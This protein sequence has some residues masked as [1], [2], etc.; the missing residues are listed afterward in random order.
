M[1]SLSLPPSLPRRK[2]SNAVL[3][4]L[5]RNNR[6]KFIIVDLNRETQRWILV[7]IRKIEN[8]SIEF[9]KVDSL[10]ADYNEALNIEFQNNCYNISIPQQEHPLC[11]GLWVLENMGA[12]EGILSRNP[13]ADHEVLRRSLTKMRNF[14]EMTSLRL[15][16]NKRYYWL[17]QV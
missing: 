17:L 9:L 5:K 15:T 14:D 10:G 3:R 6:Y 2:V 11:S 8:D 13:L 16:L 7:V 4:S 12:L 1:V